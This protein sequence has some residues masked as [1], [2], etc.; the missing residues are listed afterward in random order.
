MRSEHASLA[1][2]TPASEPGH[3]QPDPE[4]P[5][6]TP[7]ATA[8]YVIRFLGLRAFVAVLERP[9]SLYNWMSLCNWMSAHCRRGSG[10]AGWDI[11]CWKCWLRT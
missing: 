9:P 5:R 8:F 2:I 10:P 6:C 11:I 3:S 1:P 4:C 7:A